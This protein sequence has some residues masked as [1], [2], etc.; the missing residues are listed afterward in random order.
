M[1]LEGKRKIDEDLNQ[2][3]S[4]K[5]EQEEMGENKTDIERG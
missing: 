2:F 4:K 5:K 1:N 3:G